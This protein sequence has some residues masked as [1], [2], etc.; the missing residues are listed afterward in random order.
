M[1]GLDPAIHVLP[2]ARCRTL[3]ARGT[4][5]PGSSPGMTPECVERRGLLRRLPLLADGGAGRKDQRL[6]DDWHG[7]RA[8]EDGADVD[9]IELLELDAVDRHDMVLELQLLEAM[10]ADEAAD[11]A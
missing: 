6:D 9:I 7:A 4:C 8:L 2:P 1:A 5:M 3:F 11:I 10:H